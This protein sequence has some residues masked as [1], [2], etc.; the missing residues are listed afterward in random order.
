MQDIKLV[1]KNFACRKNEASKRGIP[2]DISFDQFVSMID[3]PRCAVTG[4]P[5]TSGHTS[6]ELRLS[7]DRVDNAVGYT[8]SNVRVVSSRMNRLKSDA[9]KDELMLIIKY[10]E[11][12]KND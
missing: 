4:K 2:W 9:T 12:N 1:R 6:E 3:S 10:M 11:K 5:L 7:F 8:Y